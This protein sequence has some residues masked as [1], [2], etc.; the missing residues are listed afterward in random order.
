MTEIA[1]MQIQGFEID[2]GQNKLFIE[3]VLSKKT[4][5]IELSFEYLRVFSP[6]KENAKYAVVSHKKL[7]KITAI[8]SVSK[9]GVRLIFDDNHSAIYSTEYL[10]VL[11]K[12]QHER[13]QDYLTQ[14]KSSGHSREARIDIKEV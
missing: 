11:G 4:T 14:L 1:K 13:W 8:E 3:F 5:V 7:V 6:G 9:H 2:Q 12:N 10:A